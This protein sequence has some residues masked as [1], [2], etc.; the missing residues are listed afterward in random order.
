VTSVAS[1]ISKYVTFDIIYMIFWVFYTGTHKLHDY[2]DPM[3][4]DR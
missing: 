4:I 2:L 3:Q 1:S